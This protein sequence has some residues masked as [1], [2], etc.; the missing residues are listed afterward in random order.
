[1]KND[2]NRD[3]N[4]AA[5]VRLRERIKNAYQTAKAEL[6]R[7]RS[8]QGFWTG[9]LSASALSTATAVS[10]LSIYQKAK[11]NEQISEL[12]QK[13]VNYL[14]STQN[15]DGGWGDT[16]KSFSNIATTYLVKS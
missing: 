6:L 8:D 1:M 7:H 5:I 10:A 11:P 3:V 2:L 16:V 14:V 15:P 13:S 12:I 4:R 9:E